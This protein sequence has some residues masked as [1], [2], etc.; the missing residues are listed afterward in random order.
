LVQ[1][2]YE[3]VPEDRRGAVKEHLAVCADCRRASSEWAETVA[4]CPRTSAPDAAF[5]ERQRRAVE[6][7][8]AAPAVGVRG[9]RPGWVLVAGAAVVA[10]WVGRPSR[11]P[12]VEPVFLAQMD[13]AEN[14]DWLNDWAEM[15]H[16]S[17]R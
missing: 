6:R 12:S 3:D 11:P 13:V 15:D 7:R 1:G 2:L 5:F 8:L 4:R 17:A 9:W 16:A 14:V 10:V